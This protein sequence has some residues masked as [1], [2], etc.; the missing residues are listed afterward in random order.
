M[1]VGQSRS[2]PNPRTRYESPKGKSSKSNKV[3]NVHNTF[4]LIALLTWRS[5]STFE[6]ERP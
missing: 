3:L 1:D 6:Q 4:M 5:P 2:L